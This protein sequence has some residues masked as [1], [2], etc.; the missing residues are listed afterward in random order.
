MELYRIKG[1]I[2]RCDLQAVRTQ[3]FEFDLGFVLQPTA[4]IILP[5]S[6]G[7][8]ELLDIPPKGSAPTVVMQKNSLRFAPL[9]SNS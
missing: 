5:P 8:A 3:G 4:E 9:D 6:D 1:R 7:Q 2:S